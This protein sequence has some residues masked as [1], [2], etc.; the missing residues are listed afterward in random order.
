MQDGATCHTA[1]IIKEYFNFVKITFIEKWPGNSPDLNPIENLWAIF[2]RKFRDRD[3]STIT[4]LRAAIDK[5]WQSID[6]K[7]LRK[8]A[9]SIPNRLRKVVLNKGYPIKY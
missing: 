5:I 2:K 9:S 7:V 4:K 6:R 8:L 1:K 3:T